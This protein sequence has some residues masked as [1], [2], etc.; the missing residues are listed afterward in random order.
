LRARHSKKVSL[1]ERLEKARLLPQ[2]ANP[3]STVG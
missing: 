1:L 3:S 2:P